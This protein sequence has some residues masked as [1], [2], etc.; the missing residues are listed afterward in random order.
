[1]DFNEFMEHYGWIIFVVVIVFVV[2]LYYVPETEGVDFDCYMEWPFVCESFFV[3]SNSVVLEIKNIDN[4]SYGVKGMIVSKCGSVSEIKDFGVD[5]SRTIFFE[6][7]AGL[8]GLVL[9]TTFSLI[10]FSENDVISSNGVLISNI[11]RAI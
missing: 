4:R 3:N 2:L 9:D 10:Y 8:K 6:C 1:M 11:S 5:E 7:K